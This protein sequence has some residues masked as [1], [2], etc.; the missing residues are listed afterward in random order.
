MIHFNC[1]LD[2]TKTWL[3]NHERTLLLP[4]NEGVFSDRQ[5]RRAPTQTHVI[6]RC[7]QNLN[8][9]LERGTPEGGGTWLRMWVTRNYM[10]LVPWM[11]LHS[12]HHNVNYLTH[13]HGQEMNS[14]HYVFL[15]PQWTVSLQSR[16]M[17]PTDHGLNP[18]K[19]GIK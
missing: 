4:I 9:L 17:G 8:R 14:L 15:R 5:I 2:C 6:N 12:V 19:Y 3:G 7:I 11:E 13:L 1:Q 16:N 18:P 10:A